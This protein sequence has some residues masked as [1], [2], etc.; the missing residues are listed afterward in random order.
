MFE[1]CLEASRLQVILITAD[2]SSYMRLI[3][4]QLEWYFLRLLQ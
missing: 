2:I 1:M 4:Y 3:T